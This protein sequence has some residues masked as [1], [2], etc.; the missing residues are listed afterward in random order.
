LQRTEAAL[1]AETAAREKAERS[2]AEAY[3]MVRDLQTKIGHA[4][5]A[6]NEAIAALQREREAIGLVRSEA[7]GHEARLQEAYEQVKAAEVVAKSFQDQL[8]SERHARKTTEKALR[9][10]ELAR[11]E[12]E[13]LVTSLTEAAERNQEALEQLDHVAPVPAAKPARGKATRAARQKPEPV[14]AEVE[15]E[16]VKWWL[17]AK[18][19][20][21]R[22]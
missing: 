4:D 10:A 14:A 13:Q 16:P 2:L 20:T 19:S 3:A 8:A 18:Q 22:R 5:L 11:E 15:P 17:N 12:A 7:D 21:K 1:A 9:V 6:K